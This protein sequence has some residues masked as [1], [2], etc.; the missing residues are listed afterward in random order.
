ML[1][2]VCVCV[3]MCAIYVTM[4]G[5]AILKFALSGKGALYMIW[6]KNRY[7]DGYQWPCQ[8]SSLCLV[9]KTGT[10]STWGHSIPL[11][12]NPGVDVDGWCVDGQVVRVLW[13]GDFVGN[14]GD[15]QLLHIT[16]RDLGA[17]NLLVM[18]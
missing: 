5:T 12:S 11:H 4:L 17:I 18:S 14:N 8:S 1:Q 7:T 16:A 10:I 9:R 6:K 2:L 3:C 13:N 15:D